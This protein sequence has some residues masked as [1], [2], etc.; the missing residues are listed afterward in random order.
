MKYR[1]Q[2]VTVLNFASLQNKYN[3]AAGAEG[4]IPSRLKGTRGGQKHTN[5]GN[6]K[7][8]SHKKGSSIDP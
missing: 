6:T 3:H 8:R 5:I 4:K 2:G 1:V 7:M